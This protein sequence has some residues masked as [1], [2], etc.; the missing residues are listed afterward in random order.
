[1]EEHT[2]FYAGNK[3]QHRQRIGIII[4]KNIKPAVIACIPCLD[5]IIMLKLRGHP[6]KINIIQVYAPT[7]DKK[8]EKI[9]QIYEQKRP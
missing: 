5:R 2:V 1:M 3:E 7:N 4:N 9:K 6:F 8:E